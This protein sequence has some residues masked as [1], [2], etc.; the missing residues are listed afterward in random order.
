MDGIED[1]KETEKFLSHIEKSGT[2]KSDT[3]EGRT[4]SLLL[5]L[6]S[7]LFFTSGATETTPIPTPSCVLPSPQLSVG[8]NA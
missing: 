2:E 1:W 4:G 7:S 3:E 8:F 5:L 6:L